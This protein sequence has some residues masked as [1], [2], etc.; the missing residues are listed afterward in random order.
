MYE[1]E[2]IIILQ[3]CREIFLIDDLTDN[4]LCT[5]NDWYF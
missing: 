1:L 3:Q 2:K 5:V 4:L